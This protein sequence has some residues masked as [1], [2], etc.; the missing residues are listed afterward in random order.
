MIE[1]KRTP[2]WENI[3]DTDR[4]YAENEGNL[5]RWAIFVVFR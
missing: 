4:K 5:F 2:E 1:I 3:L